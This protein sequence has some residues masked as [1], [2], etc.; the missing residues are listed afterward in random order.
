MLPPP[1]MYS[2][3]RTITLDKVG[4]GPPI[5]VMDQ[6]SPREATKEAFDGR[7]EAE[8]ERHHSQWK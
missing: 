6:D 7:E 5:V 3:A 1:P 8:E 4:R 2:P